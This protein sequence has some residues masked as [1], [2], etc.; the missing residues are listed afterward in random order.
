MLESIAGEVKLEAIKIRTNPERC[1]TDGSLHLVYINDT[2]I[3][4]PSQ[5][6]F[7]IRVTSL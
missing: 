6:N 7:N 2:K 1:C 5:I 4:N 3:K